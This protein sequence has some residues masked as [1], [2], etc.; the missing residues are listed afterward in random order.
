VHEHNEGKDQSAAAEAHC[1]IEAFRLMPDGIAGRLVGVPEQNG[2]KRIPKYPILY[3]LR[4]PHGL[5]VGAKKSDCLAKRRYCVS[6]KNLFVKHRRTSFQKIIVHVVEDP[7]CEQEPGSNVKKIY[8]TSRT[9]ISNTD[10][11]MSLSV[12]SFFDLQFH[13]SS[14]CLQPPE[15]GSIPTPH[16]RRQ[17]SRECKI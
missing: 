13:P 3:L 12:C 2:M 7:L 16:S 4:P 10:L 11:L 1:A 5:F 15:M 17:A 9:Q 14:N 6:K 8:S